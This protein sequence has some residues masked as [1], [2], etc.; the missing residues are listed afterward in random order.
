MWLPISCIR[1]WNNLWIITVS[2]SGLFI[3][4]IPPFFVV[5]LPSHIAQ[6]NL[7]L[8]SLHVHSRIMQG[9]ILS[10]WYQIYIK[11]VNSTLQSCNQKYWLWVC[12]SKRRRLLNIYRE[13]NFHL[14]RVCTVWG[15]GRQIIDH[16]LKSLFLLSSYKVLRLVYASLKTNKIVLLLKQEQMKYRDS[17]NKILSWQWFWGTMQD[18]M[19]S[20]ARKGKQSSK[21]CNDS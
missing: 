9:K 15:W 18:E 7:D 14:V 8:H 2:F 11:Q 6:V 21:I 19:N 3:W 10:I 12:F 16:D 17:R 4:K 5:P 13:I 20:K 1:K